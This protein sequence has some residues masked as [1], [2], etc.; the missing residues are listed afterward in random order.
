MDMTSTQTALIEATR[1]VAAARKARRS[2]DFAAAREAAAKA[3]TAAGLDAN[4]RHHS[5]AISVG[6]E[7]ELEDLRA[8]ADRL[9]AASVSAWSAWGKLINDHCGGPKWERPLASLYGSL[10]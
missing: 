4:N 2:L 6:V 1:E 8:E 9:D 7:M 5:H 10:A 3:Q